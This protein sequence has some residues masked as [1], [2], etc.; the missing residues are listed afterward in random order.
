VRANKDKI[1][2]AVE[3]LF[4][5]KVTGVKTMQYKGKS[6]KV[7]RSTGVTSDWKKAVV[8]LKSGMKIEMFEGV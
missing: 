1:R 6:K 2:L 5:V 8:T 7:G 4:K 3:K